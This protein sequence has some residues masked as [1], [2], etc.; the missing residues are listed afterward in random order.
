MAFPKNL[1]KKHFFIF[2]VLI[3]L[4]YVTTFFN[5]EILGK[6]W[7]PFVIFFEI[8]MKVHFL[9]V[10]LLNWRKQISYCFLICIT[11]T[12][13]FHSIVIKSP[14]FSCSEAVHTS[15]NRILILSMFFFEKHFMKKPPFH[16]TNFQ[17]SS[18]LVLWKKHLTTLDSKMLALWK[19]FDIWIKVR[20]LCLILSD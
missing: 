8:W 14:W 2:K 12:D 18:Q 1:M 19:Y 15:K 6:K 7:Q 20:F 3:N 4:Y 10:F 5:L 16:K 11:W 13:S 9:A 17:T